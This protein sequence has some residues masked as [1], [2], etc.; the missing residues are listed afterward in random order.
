MVDSQSFLVAIGYT[1]QDR[2]DKILV[3]PSI[4]PR[5]VSK[6]NTRASVIPVS[7]HLVLTT[8]SLFP[9]SPSSEEPHQP[10][11]LSPERIQ[12]M[13]WGEEP[14]PYPLACRLYYLCG[15]EVSVLA[16]RVLRESGEGKESDDLDAV[17]ETVQ[18]FLSDD[19]LILE[20][21]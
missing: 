19:Q 14:I 10:T 17:I 7:D 21:Q 13:T 4:D 20:G 5:L 1:R 15:G 16:K 6:M 18:Q 8:S 3:P 12:W 2:V 9:G 11:T